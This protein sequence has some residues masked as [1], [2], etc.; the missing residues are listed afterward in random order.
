MA[1]V[2]GLRN[3]FMAAASSLAQLEH[4]GD[5]PEHLSAYC[6]RDNCEVGPPLVLGLGAFVHANT[7]TSTAHRGHKSP[8]KVAGAVHMAQNHRMLSLLTGSTTPTIPTAST[9][10]TQ[11]SVWT[12]VQLYAT[13]NP[14][15]G[16]VPKPITGCCEMSPSKVGAEHSSTEKQALQRT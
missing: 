11:S 13:R 1:G 3:L 9:L 7:D 16:M 12:L 6:M 5:W 10:R 2:K 14:E 15:V 4:S 8:H